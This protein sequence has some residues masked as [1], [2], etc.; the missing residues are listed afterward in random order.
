MEEAPNAIQNSSIAKD[1]DSWN[2][3]V[4]R[5]RE[6]YKNKHGHYPNQPPIYNEQQTIQILKQIKNNK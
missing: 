4:L 2:E 3:R 5:G 1:K 6:I